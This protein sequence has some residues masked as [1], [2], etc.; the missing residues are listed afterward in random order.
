MNSLCTVNFPTEYKL[1]RAY[2][3]FS[4]RERTSLWEKAWVYA[5]AVWPQIIHLNFLIAE[6]LKISKL[7]F[8]NTC[9]WVFL[10]RRSEIIPG[11]CL[12][13]CRVLYKISI[14][15]SGQAILVRWLFFSNANA[16]QWLLTK[17]EN[18]WGWVMVYL[19]LYPPYSTKLGTQKKLNH[20]R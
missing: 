13:S 8:N 15:C 6:F 10:G 5:L 16:C 14:L 11:K 3:F 4:D 18:F 7:R 17:L 2:T 20:D 12:L 9:K 1:A 19:C